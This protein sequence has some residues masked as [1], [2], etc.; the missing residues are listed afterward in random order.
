MILNT[1]DPCPSDLMVRTAPV[2]W[3]VIAHSAPGTAAPELSRTVARNELE[4]FCANARLAAQARIAINLENFFMEPPI[5]PTTP[6]A[7]SEPRRGPVSYTHL[8]AH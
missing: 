1:H 4:T 2:F 3:L 6:V 7:C 8:R 5:V